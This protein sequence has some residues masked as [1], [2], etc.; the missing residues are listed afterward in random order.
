[1]KQEVA[2]KAAPTFVLRRKTM[3]EERKNIDWK[4]LLSAIVLVAL[5]ATAVAQEEGHLNV[6]TVVQKEQVTMNDAGE[7]ETQL[8][9]ADTVIPG[10]KVVYT[11]TFQNISEEAADNVVITNPISGDLTYVD[12][13]EFGPG[14]DIQFSVDGGQTFANKNELTV[15]EDG[16]TRSAVAEDFTHIRWVMQQELAAGAQGVARFSAVLK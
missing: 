7:A 4:A 6:R 14:T 8:V 12:G 9:A 11:I 3:S 15:T 2:A 10:E 13:S 16:V 5:S 1:M